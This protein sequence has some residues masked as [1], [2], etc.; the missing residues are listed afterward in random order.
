MGANSKSKMPTEI[1]CYCG[2]AKY[3]VEMDEPAMQVA[4]HCEDCRRWGGGVFQA[5]KLFPMEGVSAIEGEVVTKETTDNHRRRSCAKCGGV[6]M[7]IITEMNM[8]MVPA[9]LF[10]DCAPFEPGMHI[11]YSKKIMSIPD[12]KPKYATFP[13][14]MGG[15]GVTCED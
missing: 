5:A 1:K 3:T 2:A 10:P 14:A 9:G 6:L 15:D 11:Q 8:R 13:E 12:G 4:C 7:D